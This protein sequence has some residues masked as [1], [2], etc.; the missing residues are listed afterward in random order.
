[1]EGG[2]DGFMGRT[3]EISADSDIC[4]GIRFNLQDT[5]IALLMEGVA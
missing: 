5:I 4:Y 1:M 2:I 3:T